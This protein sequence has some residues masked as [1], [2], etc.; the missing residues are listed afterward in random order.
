MK[1]SKEKQQRTLKE[2]I[3]T[4]TRT[5]LE[6]KN[7]NT[8]AELVKRGSVSKTLIQCNVPL[9]RYVITFVL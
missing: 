8:V 3:R 5:K 2:M 6:E 9:Y 4:K 1:M 7:S